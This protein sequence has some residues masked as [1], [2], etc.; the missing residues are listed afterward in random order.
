MSRHYFSKSANSMRASRRDGFTLIELLVVIAIIAI[1]AAILFPAFAKARESARAT[2]CMSNS[3]QLGMGIM[4]YVQEY[5]ETYMPAYYNTNGINL[6][7]GYTQWSYLV[8]PFLK[9]YSIFVCPS[10]SSDGLAPTNF[11]GDNMGKGAPS[12][13]LSANPVQDRQAPRLSYIPNGII[14]AR[15]RR[16]ADPERVVPMSMI[17]EP[18][19]TIII[20]EMTDLPQAIND[21]SNFNG[22]AFKTH[23]GTHAIKTPSGGVYAGEAASEV[24]LPN[25]VAVTLDDAKAAIAAATAP[26]SNA[27]G[28]HRICYTSPE[29]HMQGSNYVFA[30][31]H[32]K[33][34]RLE[35]TL[36]PN[37]FMWGKRAYSAGGGVVLDAEGN[38][39]R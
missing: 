15:K 14:L 8:Q 2:S 23:R 34:F 33:R 19:S 39:V 6:V 32:A 13:Q 12:G 16:V 36:D 37:N 38:P 22:V 10:D 7:Q 31:G 26:N 4:Q 20:A 3:R 30:D 35:Q 11:V 27:F 28:Q 24:G 9:S 17:D 18:S 29:R 5:D 1:L 21:I 25:Y